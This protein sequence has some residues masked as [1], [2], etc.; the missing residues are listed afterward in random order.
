[1]R[2]SDTS[3]LLLFTFSNSIAE[4]LEHPTLYRTPKQ[5]L[6]FLNLKAQAET[7]TPI[8]TPQ[9][10]TTIRKTVTSKK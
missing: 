9:T 6:S 2:V 7:E 4:S 3:Y 5:L 8:E 10:P 1:M